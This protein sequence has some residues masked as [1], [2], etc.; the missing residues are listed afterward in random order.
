[1]NWHNLKLGDLVRGAYP[2]CPRRALY[3]GIITDRD[4]DWLE[5]SWDDGGVDQFDLR[6]PFAISEM[7]ECWEVVS[8]SR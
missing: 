5:I 4:G 1:M 6:E 7:E 8:E 2:N 3:L